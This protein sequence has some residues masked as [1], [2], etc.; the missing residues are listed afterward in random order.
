MVHSRHEVASGHTPG[1]VPDLVSALYKRKDVA[2]GSGSPRSVAHAIPSAA[3]LLNYT[4]KRKG[5]RPQLA[6]GRLHQVIRLCEFDCCGLASLDEARAVT[7]RLQATQAFLRGL[8][9]TLTR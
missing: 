7:R 2:R 5:D 1:A 8:T 6:L 9:N 3:L 4:I